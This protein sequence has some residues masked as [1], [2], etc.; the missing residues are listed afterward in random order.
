MSHSTLKTVDALIDGL[1]LR[2]RSQAIEQLV[3]EAIEHQYVKDAVILIKGSENDI[4][5]KHVD[6]KTILEQQAIW[7]RTHGIQQIYLLTGRSGAS[8]DIQKLS[9]Q[10]NITLITEEHEQGTVPALLKLKNRL[11]KQFVVVL[12][13]TLNEFDLTKMILFHLKQDKPATIGLISSE[14]PEKYSPVELEGDRIV[15][16]RPKESGSHIIDAGIYIFTPHI[17]THLNKEMR[18]LDKDLFPK[19]C[20]TNEIKGYFTRG[21]YAHY[22]R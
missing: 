12:G 13:D 16:F 5:L 22:G 10:L 8:Q 15:E 6:G 2:N 21:K 20:Q 17:F 11:H 1:S 9:D 3:L 19:L 18:L 4:L 7:L 14:T